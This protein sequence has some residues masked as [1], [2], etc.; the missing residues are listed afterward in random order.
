MYKCYASDRSKQH[1]KL[2]EVIELKYADVLAKISMDK[3]SLEKLKLAEIRFL[4]QKNDRK[5]TVSKG[6]GIDA[7]LELGA[8]K[9][10]A[11]VEQAD[12]EKKKA[13]EEEMKAKEEKKQA[14]QKAAQEKA[15]AKKAKAKEQEEK[16]QAKQK[17]KEEEKEKALQ[18]ATTC[19][20]HALSEHQK[21]NFDQA[22]KLFQWAAG[23]YEKAGESLEEPHHEN[24]E[25]ART[26]RTPQEIQK[27]AQEQ[28]EAQK[29][30]QEQAEAQY[31]AA[32]TACAFFEQA[33]SA[34]KQAEFVTAQDLFAKAARA[35]DVAGKFY[36]EQQQQVYDFAR[37]YTIPEAP[38]PAEGWR[39]QWSS[40][41]ECFFFEHLETKE[42]SWARPAEAQPCAA[43][44]TQASQAAAAGSGM[45][46]A[47]DD[48]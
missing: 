46:A 31:K 42:I 32:Q 14:K 41:S 40:V 21:G 35:F 23:W 24:A 48:L 15:E 11:E 20:S 28:A 39:V 45:G 37:C 5:M 8:L 10:A 3:E 13:E 34:H 1:H 19:Q 38:A 43:Q 44:A 7:L 22:R 18:N 9:S 36:Q 17:K 4:L 16:K 30:A 12:K 33:H 27:I 2:C 29:V 25:F 47:D 6:P 26:Y